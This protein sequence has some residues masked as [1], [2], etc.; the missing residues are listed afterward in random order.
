MKSKDAVMYRG[1]IAAEKLLSYYAI[2]H[3]CQIELEDL[4]AMRNVFVIEGTLKGAEAR[5]IRL[6]KN[7]LIRVRRDIPEIGRR[8]FAIAHE[9]GHWERHSGISQISY[10]LEEDIQCYK[11]SLEEIEANSF[12]GGL[13]APTGFL[14]ANYNATPSIKLV[15]EISQDLLTS[16]TVSAVRL[17]ETTRE[18]C[19]VV[20]S[21]KARVQ[22]WR[23]SPTVSNIWLESKQII[24]DRSVTWSVFKHNETSVGSERVE[25]DAWFSHVPKK[26]RLKVYEEALLLGRY[27]TVLTLLRIDEW[28]GY[29]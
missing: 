6:D 19:I 7:G 16:L 25:T 27:E 8:R 14:R 5:L 3:P 23:S 10:C 4:A 11:G 9:L 26:K 15:K 17:V 13:L 28:D 2:D 22:W 20:F 21:K 12:A 29:F 18:P 1:L 24:S